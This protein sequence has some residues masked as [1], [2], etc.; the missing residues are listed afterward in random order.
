M[1]AV[2]R[3]RSRA[4]ARLKNCCKHWTVRTASLACD[5][6]QQC[7]SLLHRPLLLAQDCQFGGPCLR[8]V[9]NALLLHS[10]QPHSRCAPWRVPSQSDG[11]ALSA[12]ERTINSDYTKVPAF[13]VCCVSHSLTQRALSGS[14]FNPKHDCLARPRRCAAPIAST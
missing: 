3:K 2:Q 8:F 14:R 7:S 1:R 6:G 10:V 11:R 4:E 13:Q 9:S 12:T 5:S